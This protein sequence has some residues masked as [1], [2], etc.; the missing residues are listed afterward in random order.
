MKI[1][2]NTTFA[3][4]F[5]VLNSRIF[6]LAL[7]A[8][9]AMLYLKQCNAT[10]YAE[11]E[12]KREH[13]NY[14]AAQDSVR[15]IKKDLNNAIYEKSA[16]EIKIKELSEQQKELI[17]QLG[18]KPKPEVKTVIQYVTQYRDTGSVKTSVV[19]EKDGSESLKFDY[20]PV[21]PGKNRFTINGKTPY[22]IN[23]ERDKLDTSKYLASIIPGETNLIISQNIEIVTGIYR[24][25]KSKRL[26]TRVSTTFPNI[27]FS[28]INSFDI[29]DDKDTRKLM[30]SARKEFGIGVMLG[31]GIS[32]TPTGIRPGVVIGV[33]LTYTP[34][35]LQFGK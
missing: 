35:F 28:E 2:S 6:L 16:Y 33:G 23:L 7:I 29:T 27:S 19:K 12:A 34:R 4:I 1:V 30:K 11:T 14:L 25:S 5:S 21:L 15:L 26:M 22:K 3:K 20:A 17:R 32:G 8:L 18:L 13:N 31:Y 9:F 24:D 10:K